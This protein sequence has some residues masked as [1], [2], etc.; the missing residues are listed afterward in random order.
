MFEDLA[1]RRQ[2][3]GIACPQ[4]LQVMAGPG[5]CCGTLS[6]G[7]GDQDQVPPVTERAF[8]GKLVFE[9]LGMGISE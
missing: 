1:R 8:V 5:R 2:C 3:G 6:W 7:T 9:G 4:L